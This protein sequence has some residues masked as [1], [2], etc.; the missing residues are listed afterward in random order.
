MLTDI[1]NGFGGVVSSALETLSDEYGAGKLLVCGC[2]PPFLGPDTVRE[3]CMVLVMSMLV[4]S[5]SN[6]IGPAYSRAKQLSGRQS[7]H[8]ELWIAP[9]DEHLSGAVAITCETRAIELSHI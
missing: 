4:Y 7:N 5:S 3:Y 9:A 2:Y 8:N 6:F 1:H